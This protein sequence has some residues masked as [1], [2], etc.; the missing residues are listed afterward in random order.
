MNKVIEDFDGH[1]LIWQIINII[2][3]IIMVYVLYLL[4]KFFR[5]KYKK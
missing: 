2:G 5:N 1:L 4:I 3:L